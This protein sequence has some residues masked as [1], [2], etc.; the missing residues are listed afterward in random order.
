MNWATLRAYA[1]PPWNLIGR[2]LA[3]TRQQQAELVLVAPIW[4][5]QIWYPVLL[6]MLVS[7]PLLI[8]PMRDLITATHPESL[9]EVIPP[10]AVWVISGNATETIRYRKELLNSSGI[11]EAKILQGI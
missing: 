8:P 10:L 11:M 2:V 6:E 4:K 7:T 1:N 3:Q 9:P 5:A